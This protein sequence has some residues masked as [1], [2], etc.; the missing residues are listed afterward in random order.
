[1]HQ[2]VA[3]GYSAAKRT[4]RTDDGCVLDAARAQFRNGILDLFILVQDERVARQ[5][6][7]D[8]QAAQITTPVQHCAQNVAGGQ[9]A[10]GGRLADVGGDGN[11]GFGTAITKQTSSVRQRRTSGHRGHITFAYVADVHVGA[12][13]HRAL[14][15][16]CLEHTGRLRI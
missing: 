9:N 15:L 5:N 6:V 11:Y 7:H 8:V 16:I 14:W 4:S 10:D 3:L 1:M 2:Q 13:P 12:R